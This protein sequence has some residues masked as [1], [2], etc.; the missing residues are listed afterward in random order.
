MNGGNKERDLKA[1]IHMHS[2]SSDGGYSP[3]VLMEKCAKAGLNIVSLTDHDTTVGIDAAR[4]VA[5]QYQ[6]TFINGIELSTRVDGVSVDILGYGI[7]IDSQTLQDKLAFHRKMRKER[8]DLMIK[9]CQD[10]GL[11]ITLENVK[12]QVTGETFSRPHLA[13][14]LIESGDVQSVQEAFEK[15][16]GYGKPCYVLKE[17]EMNPQEAISLIHQAGGVAIVAHP[18]YYD[19]DDQISEWFHDYR[20]DGIEVYHRDHDPSHVERFQRLAE[21]IEAKLNIKIYKTGGSDFHHESFGRV[22]EEIGVTKLP[23]SEALR[24]LN[25]LQKT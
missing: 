4:K 7:N 3:E 14:A 25:D 5:E 17:D 21:K 8:M 16:L 13:K 20:L 6:M 2:T 18:V 9:K 24:L 22:G 15:Y 23:Y 11:N 19:L 1:D 12:A 10:H